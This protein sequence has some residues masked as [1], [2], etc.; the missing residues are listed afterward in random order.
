MRIFSKETLWRKKKSTNK[1]F[2]TNIIIT[3]DR[4]LY[5]NL[6]K[7]ATLKSFK[8]CL[9]KIKIKKNKRE[10][11]DRKNKLLTRMKKLSRMIQKKQ[12]KKKKK[13]KA[14]Y[15]SSFQRKNNKMRI[16]RCSFKAM[17]LKR[18]KQIR[19]R[20]WLRRQKLNQ[21]QKQ[22]YLCRCMPY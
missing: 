8:N 2:K 10:Q 20:K 16:K 7:K 18:R 12:N 11:R 5:K 14:N 1:E 4:N 13:K 6:I 21:N 22:V 19:F 17:N 15:K 3:L 9:Q